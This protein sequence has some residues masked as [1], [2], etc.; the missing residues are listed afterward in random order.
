MTAYITGIKRITQEVH[1]AAQYVVKPERVT[2]EEA[3]LQKEMFNTRAKIR[4]VTQTLFIGFASAYLL[5]GSSNLGFGLAFTAG[6]T[7]ALPLVLL[8]ETATFFQRILG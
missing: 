2:Q 6:V 8:K 1:T 3:Y 7:V 4:I 5:G